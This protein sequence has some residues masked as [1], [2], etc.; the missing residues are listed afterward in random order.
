MRLCLL[1]YYSSRIAF[2]FETVC[3][4]LFCNIVSSKL[5]ILLTFSQYATIR[6]SV[7]CTVAFNPVEFLNCRNQRKFLFLLF[8]LHFAY[9][10][11]AKYFSLFTDW[12]VTLLACQKFERVNPCIFRTRFSAVLY[13]DFVRC[14]SFLEPW[15]IFSLNTHVEHAQRCSIQIGTWQIFERLK[16]HA[17]YCFVHTD[18]P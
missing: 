2:H 16:I 15:N 8:T 11:I 18:S 3:L 17:L 1:Q 9:L 12:E 6:R 14:Q 13:M 4:F 7:T 5:C 10:M